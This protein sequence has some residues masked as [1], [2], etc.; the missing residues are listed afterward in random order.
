MTQDNR[1][2][3]LQEIMDTLGETVECDQLVNKLADKNIILRDDVTR[4]THVEEND[5]LTELLQVLMEKGE[6]LHPLVTII[7]KTLDSSSRHEQ[8]PRETDLAIEAVSRG[9]SYAAFYRLEYIT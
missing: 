7:L 9:M 2:E 5:Q 4:I 1:Q 8:D 3:T 6:E